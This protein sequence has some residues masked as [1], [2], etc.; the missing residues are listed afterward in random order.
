MKKATQSPKQPKKPA[1]KRPHTG[2]MHTGE[3]VRAR[4][5]ADSPEDYEWAKEVIKAGFRFREE[6][7][8]WSMNPDDAWRLA[9]F[10][11]DEDDWKLQMESLAAHSLHDENASN[12]GGLM[13]SCCSTIERIWQWLHH[14]TQHAK[15]PN[16]KDE[17]GR[18][19][20]KL[21]HQAGQKKNQQKLRAH[22]QEF[23]RQ[24]APFGSSGVKPTK[25]L[26]DWISQQMR[27]HLEF[28]T[29]A[30]EVAQQFK[31][32]RPYY[33][34]RHSGG[35]SRRVMTL[36]GTHP[37][38]SMEEAWKGYLTESRKRDGTGR[39]EFLDSL[40]IHPFCKAGLTLEQLLDF[41]ACWNRALES[42]LRQ[43]WAKLSAK[44]KQGIGKDLSFEHRVGTVEYPKAG[45]WVAKDIFDRIFLPGWQQRQK[46]DQFLNK[47]MQREFLGTGTA[48]DPVA[49]K[50]FAKAC[51]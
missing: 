3:R 6:A 30:T 33:E 31:E 36:V 11:L 18:T 50:I 21:Y 35:N 13:D 19:L 27:R 26:I 24:I 46:R 4:F 17:A 2:I 7:D 28:W 48:V 49:K 29:R 25:A 41:N 1:N 38:N 22:N 15:N 14:L 43:R 16:I 51:K 44:E 12:F 42:V 20:G 8:S 9:C 39:V 40:E 23:E 47:T 5:E 37:M 32:K 45:Y 34:Y 10:P